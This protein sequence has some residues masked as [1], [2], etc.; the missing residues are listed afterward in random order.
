MKPIL[1]WACLSGVLAILAILTP[2]QGATC[3]N[4]E[5]VIMTALNIASCDGTSAIALSEVKLTANP[6]DGNVVKVTINHLMS[7]QTVATAGDAIWLYYA[8]SYDARQFSDAYA[9][10]V[11]LD[12]NMIASPA[13]FTYTHTARGA[14]MPGDQLVVQPT[15]NTSNTSASSARTWSSDATGIADIDMGGQQAA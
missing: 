2:C 14:L 15:Y 13:L 3:Q 9:T 8:P 7:G 11:V 5:A 4:D 6:A 12:A 1:R 10:T